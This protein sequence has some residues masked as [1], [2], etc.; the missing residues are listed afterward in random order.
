MVRSPS[1]SFSY[2]SYVPADSQGSP[3][4]LASFAESRH[5]FSP[6]KDAA[7]PPAA[8]VGGKPLRHPVAGSCIDLAGAGAEP[9]CS[10]HLGRTVEQLRELVQQK[11]G[12]RA[13]G[14]VSGNGPGFRKW[15]GKKDCSLSCCAVVPACCCCPLSQLFPCKS[16]SNLKTSVSP[17]APADPEAQRRL[18]HEVGS[19]VDL[20]LGACPSAPVTPS[21][22]CPA[23]VAAAAGAG[24]SRSVPAALDGLW[25]DGLG[26]AEDLCAICMD[27]PVTV[28][29]RA[30]IACSPQ[31]RRCPAPHSQRGLLLH[32]RVLGGLACAGWRMLA[33]CAPT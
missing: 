10:Q 18:D 17:R 22:A 28:Q 8:V 29:V 30:S 27:R 31:P 33:P 21:G 16:S 25:V 20:I 11:G 13:G 19:L 15:K 5:R 26:A 3:L 14:R 6:S 12:C 23:A 9:E 4:L 32:M 2:F 7:E 1:V 24:R